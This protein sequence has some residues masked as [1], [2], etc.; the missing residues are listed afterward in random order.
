MAYSHKAPRTWAGAGLVVFSVAMLA[1]TLAVRAG[2]APGGAAPKLVPMT[3][4]TILRDPA[5]HLG[6]TVS[7]MAAVET[8]LTE[9]PQRRGDDARPGLLATRIAGVGC[10]A[11]FCCLCHRNPRLAS[12]G[13]LE[14]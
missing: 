12:G 13:S 1:T 6:E 5:A 3:A 14:R 2:Q 8:V 7:L 10:M 9:Q 11:V 4:S